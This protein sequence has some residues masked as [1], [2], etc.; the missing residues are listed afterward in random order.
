[1]RIK[2]QSVTGYISIEHYFSDSEIKTPIDNKRLFLANEFYRTGVNKQ[3]STLYYKSNP[4]FF[5]T[6][7]IIEHETNNYVTNINGTGDYSISKA[8][9]V[10]C[11][12]NNVENF[13][14]ISFGEFVKIFNIIDKIYSDYSNNN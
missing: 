9:F 13:K 12:E 11:I 14:E 7:K 10:E 1:M 5:D 8:R 2:N 6:I 4:A 3:D